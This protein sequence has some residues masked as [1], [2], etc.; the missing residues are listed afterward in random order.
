[1]IVIEDKK[2]LFCGK[3]LTKKDYET[4]RDFKSGVS[5]PYIDVDKLIA[6]FQGEWD[7]HD[8]QCIRQ[9]V[10]EGEFEPVIY[11]HWFYGWNYD[12]CSNC[13]YE[14]GKSACPTKRCPECG[15]HMKGV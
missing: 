11:A 7:W 3:I 12:K 9:F 13:G 6:Y 14:T 1:M 15:A 10:E 8:C 4:S 2:C 5:M